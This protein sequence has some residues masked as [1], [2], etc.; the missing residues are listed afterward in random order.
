MTYG[1]S[2]YHIRLQPPPHTVARLVMSR[3]DSLS[4][5][6]MARVERQSAV[7]TPATSALTPERSRHL[8]LGLG[9]GVGLGVG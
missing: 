3:S 7:S 2:L 8:G 9:L 6:Y 5:S 1:C 4:P